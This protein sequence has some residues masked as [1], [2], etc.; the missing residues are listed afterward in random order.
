MALTD[1][2]FGAGSSKCILFAQGYLEKLADALK[3][4][5]CSTRMSDIFAR[6]AQNDILGKGEGDNH[7]TDHFIREGV[8]KKTCC[9]AKGNG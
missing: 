6:R 4:D 7:L 8:C 5:M 2:M 1:D 3:G 9:S